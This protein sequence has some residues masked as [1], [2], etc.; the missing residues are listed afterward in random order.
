[1]SLVISYYCKCHTSSVSCFFLVG[2]AGGTSFRE[3][4][5]HSRL[6]TGCQWRAVEYVN[7]SLSTSCPGDVFC[8]CARHFDWT[9]IQCMCDEGVQV[10]PL[11]LLRDPIRRAVSHFYFMKTLPWSEG[12]R[13]RN[14]T[15][16]EFLNDPASMLESRD[17]WQDGQAAVSWLS[18]T[19]I[20]NFVFFNS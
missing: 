17:V 20:G 1:M 14:Q 13:M 7:K 9:V 12:T 18:G 2:K 4:L 16:S 8:V 11:V 5:L 10:A 19:H 3:A 6:K 15:L